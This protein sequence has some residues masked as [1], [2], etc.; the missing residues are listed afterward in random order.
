MAIAT[1]NLLLLSGIIPLLAHAK[2]LSNNMYTCMFDHK[3]LN[4]GVP[5]AYQ[6]SGSGDMKRHTAALIKL[7]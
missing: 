7:H 2:H 4:H 5:T 3:I 1:V 6:L